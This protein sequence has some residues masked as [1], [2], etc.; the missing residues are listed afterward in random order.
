[1]APVKIRN[2]GAAIAEPELWLIDID[3]SAAAL[4]AAEA[5]R[6]LLSESDEERISALSDAGMR[7]ARRVSH[8]ALRLLIERAF[9]A[10]WRQVPYVISETG[11]PLL[12]GL[13]GGFSLSHTRGLALIGMTPEGPIGV[14]I[15]RT[16]TLRI[17]QGRRDALEHAGVVLAGGVPL[18]G[19]DP[20]ER[21][22]MA[23]VRFEAVAKA[24]GCGIG[25][26]LSRFGLGRREI[27]AEVMDIDFLAHDVEVGMGIFAAAAVRAGQALG[28]PRHLPHTADGLEALIS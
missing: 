10:R 26:L 24:E 21:L 20:D 9:G 17:P 2:T 4:E 8:I 27:A 14:D 13:E 25:P 23:W 6:R 11:K 19:G 16:R 12:E 22:L 18:Q 5:S 28:L 15:E 3:A 1:M 7:R